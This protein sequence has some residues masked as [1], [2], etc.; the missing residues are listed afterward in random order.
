M[1]FLEQGTAQWVGPRVVSNQVEELQFLEV[2][3]QV[4]MESPALVGT[5]VPSILAVAAIAV[6]GCGGCSFLM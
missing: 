4:E 2:R 1:V 5:W 3:L 6:D